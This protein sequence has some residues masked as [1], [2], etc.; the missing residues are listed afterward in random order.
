MLISSW[1]LFY[2]DAFPL[3]AIGGFFA[4]ILFFTFLY[5]P[6]AYEIT[7][8]HIAIVRRIGNFN[9]PRTEIVSVQALSKQ[10]MGLAWRTMGNGGLF[11]YTGWYASQKQGR[12]RWF[13]SQRNNYVMIVLANQK[14]YI[15]TPDD[16][17]GFMQFTQW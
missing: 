10:D 11:G 16:V 14:K 3:L 15:L 4:V 12:M 2:A 17:E 6:L 9:I 8:D 1:F 13:V 5:A 7:N